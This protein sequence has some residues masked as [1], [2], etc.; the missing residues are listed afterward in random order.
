MVFVPYILG[1]VLLTAVAFVLA[2]RGVSLRVAYVALPLLVL[3]GLGG[4]LILAGLG[5]SLRR[6]V[7]SAL[8]FAGVVLLTLCVAEALHPR[9]GGTGARSYV[10]GGVL[11]GVALAILLTVAAFLRLLTGGWGDEV[12]TEDGQKMVVESVGIFQEV[13]YRYVNPFVHGDQIWEWND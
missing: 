13:G 12:R 1:A 6:W 4:I 8:F 2:G 7:V 11:W 3:L 5:L 10:A 9:V